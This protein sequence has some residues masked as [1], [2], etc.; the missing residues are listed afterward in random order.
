MQRFFSLEQ[1]NFKHNRV[2]GASQTLRNVGGKKCKYR[3]PIPYAMSYLSAWFFYV[4]AT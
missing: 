2:T 1:L 3:Y 4:K